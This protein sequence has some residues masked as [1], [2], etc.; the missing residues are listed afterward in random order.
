MILRI[1]KINICWKFLVFSV[2]NLCH[3]YKSRLIQSV[4]NLLSYLIETPDGN[5]EIDAVSPWLLIY[6]LLK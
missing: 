4:I 3:G 1:I 6:N 5:P 2:K